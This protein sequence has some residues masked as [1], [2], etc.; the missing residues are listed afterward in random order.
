MLYLLEL[1]IR[2]LFKDLQK[3]K[4][5]NLNSNAFQLGV[6]KQEEHLDYKTIF[7]L[8]Q[9]KDKFILKLRFFNN[10]R[11]TALKNNVKD[12]SLVLYANTR[13]INFFQFG[14]KCILKL[15]FI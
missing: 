7:N 11:L 15:F 10:F 13:S 6:L 9:I 2:N 12:K 4:Y 3:K 14:L 1:K 8:L 5:K